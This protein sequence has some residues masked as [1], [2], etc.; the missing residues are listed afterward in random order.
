M[1][2]TLLVYGSPGAPAPAGPVPDPGGDRG[3]PSAGGGA[4]RHRLGPDRAALRPPRRAGRLDDYAPLHAAHADLLEAAG[5]RHGAAAAWRR[6]VA[7]TDNA[8]TLA[9]L[10]DRLVAGESG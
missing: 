9:H 5:D 3:G 10:R 8:A 1:A 2:Y 7:A 4:G 6:A